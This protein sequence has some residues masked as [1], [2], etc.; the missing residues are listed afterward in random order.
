M[1][2]RKHPD[3]QEC[4]EFLRD[5]GTPGHVVGHCKSVAAVAYRL[6]QYINAAGGT[7]ALPLDDIELEQC[8]REDDGRRSYYRQKSTG[9]G[10]SRQLDLEL[11]LA[12]GL[13]HD[14]AR[15]EDRH[16]DVCADYLQERGFEEESRLIRVHMTYE[17]TNDGS[18]VTE[19]DLLCLGDRLSLEDRYAGLDKRMDYIIAKAERNG[20]P[21]ARS[22]ILAKKEQ[23]RTLLNDIEKITG[24]SV[25]E[26][27]RDLNYENTENYELG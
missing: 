15:V 24:L 6:G 23:T 7:K 18:H 22:R 9:E 25:D 20:N 14:M 1:T 10:D 21:Q 2:T 13:L 17:F 27:M 26:M 19:V 4:M 16:W 12:A 3:R 11:V 5:Y 8:T